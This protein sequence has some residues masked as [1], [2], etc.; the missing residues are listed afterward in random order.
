[1]KY[2][3]DNVKPVVQ[4]YVKPTVHKYLDP[5]VKTKTFKAIKKIPGAKQVINGVSWLA[6]AGLW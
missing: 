1:V 6:K 4:K 3:N 5:I 2:Y